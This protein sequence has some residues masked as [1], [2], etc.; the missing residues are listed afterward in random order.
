MGSIYLAGASSRARTTKEYLEKLNPDLKVRAFLVSPEMDDNPGEA[1]GIPVITI[2][3]EFVFSEGN[4]TLSSESGIDT[5]ARVYIG[6]R[7]VNHEKL[8]HELLAIGFALDNII[9]VTPTLDTELRNEY[10]RKAFEHKGKAFIKLE[11]LSDVYSQEILSGIRSNDVIWHQSETEQ[12]GKD[13]TKLFIAKTI[14]D[15]AFT[16]DV[17]LKK[18]EYI[19]QAGTAL[20]QNSSSEVSPSAANDKTGRL[21]DASF[22]D[23]DGDNIS[24]KNPHFCELTAMYWIW[25]NSQDEIVGLEHWRRRFLLP[26]NWAE[27]MT[28][29][30]YDVI[31]PVPLCVMPSLKENFVTRHLPI[32]WETTMEIIRKLYPEDAEKAEEYFTKNNLYS[33]CNMLIAR[34]EVFDDYSAWLFPIL[35]ELNYRIGEVEDKYQNRYP[36]FVS[37]RLLNYYFDIRRSDL[38]IAYSDK[39]FLS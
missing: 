3:K 28:G 12:L 32:F 2:S 8:T 19:L 16:K 15:G 10:V 6:T 31:L 26:D 9:P 4:T 38:K 30:G 37:E 25:K 21:T 27:L 29:N 35:L 1:D 18:Y 7:G 22:F 20:S 39:S 11:S 23:N 13:G 36:G 17:P 14:F 24:D 33:P 34:K 5:S